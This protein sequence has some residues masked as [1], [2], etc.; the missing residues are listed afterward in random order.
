MKPKTLLLLGVAVV[1]GVIGM[2]MAAMLLG[3]PRDA[4]T[5]TVLVVKSQKPS[6]ESDATDKSDDEIPPGTYLK[7][8]WDKNPDHTGMEGFLEDNRF[9]TKV[10]Y[11]KGQ[12]PKNAITEPEKL[13]GRIL[14]HSLPAGQFV[15][16]NDL[17]P[18]SKVVEISEE[19]PAREARAQL[20][21]IRREVKNADSFPGGGGSW[22]AQL[23]EIAERLKKADTLKRKDGTEEQKRHPDY[24]W[25]YEGKKEDQKDTKP[26]AVAEFRSCRDRDAALKVLDQMDRRLGLIQHKWIAVAVAVDA[27]K[28]AGGF[29]RPH[30]HV[31]MLYSEQ[32]PKTNK[33]RTRTILFD[34][35]VLGLDNMAEFPPDLKAYNPKTLTLALTREQ[36]ERLALA[37]DR[38]RFTFIVLRQDQYGEEAAESR[39]KNNPWLYGTGENAKADP[40]TI[41]PPPVKVYVAKDDIL[42]SKPLD[43]ELF[44]AVEFSLGEEP[45]TYIAD[46]PAF[47]K[48]NKEC[49]LR[50]TLAAGKWLTVDALDIPAGK[51]DP[52][53]LPQRPNLL[54]VKNGKEEAYWFYR[55]PGALAERVEGAANTEGKSLTVKNDGGAWEIEGDDL[56]GR[57]LKLSNFRGKVVVLTFWAHSSEHNRS[58][59]MYPALKG[60]AKDLAKEPAVVFV[61]VN[62]DASLAAAQ[63]ADHTEKLPGS[64]WWDQ[65]RELAK[66][67]N[68]PGIPTLVVL[69]PK[70][71]VRDTFVGVQDKDLV[72]ARIANL[73]KEREQPKEN[74]Q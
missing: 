54:L 41:K 32:D 56:E 66:R 18:R 14:A 46:L 55:E 13:E 45:Q 47:L 31:D 36:S 69:D 64:S 3:R 65:D 70:G 26:S 17:L 19:L 67:M 58:R 15:T 60:L 28:S 50:K 27:E 7:G 9:F 63:Q 51:I 62:V 44:K 52:I 40:G 53:P 33:W 6:G 61:G 5:V 72:K 11:P 68:V 30:S 34:V 16:E 4:G 10:T 22:S 38:G 59:E 25:F 73:L 57:K 8:I 2:Y 20:D 48:Q 43:I 35:E 49:K 71:V 24:T 23:D 37:A 42:P 12:E 39:K 21:V 74:A 1:F 29:I